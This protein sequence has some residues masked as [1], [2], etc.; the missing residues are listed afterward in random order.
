[1]KSSWTLLLSLALALLRLF[2]R[3][4]GGEKPKPKL[5]PPDKELDLT[6]R[7][8]SIYEKEGHGIPVSFLRTLA[9]RESASNPSEASGP[10]WGLLQVGIDR[11]AGNVLKSY[12]KRFGTSYTKSDMLNPTLNVRV[13]TDLLSRIV[14]LYKREGIKTDWRN[15]NFV[16][17]VVAGWNSGYS[18]KT[19]VVGVVRYLRGR[20][21]PVTLENVYKYAKAAGMTRHLSNEKKQKWHRGVVRSYFDEPEIPHAVRRFEP[22]WL[23][24]ALLAFMLT[25]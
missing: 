6:N 2:M 5:E 22:T 8:D 17:L 4:T 25:R 19:G 10:A 7:F 23:P 11:R 13:A 9:K 3:A 21:L 20:R 14:K 16:G 15:G 18:I 24:L 12:N 1:M